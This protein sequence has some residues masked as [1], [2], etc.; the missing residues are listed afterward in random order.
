MTDANGHGDFTFHLPNSVAAGAFI[1]A[2]ATDAAGNTS[3]FSACVEA[4]FAIVSAVSRKTHGGA[5]EFDIPLPLSGAPGVECRSSGG[6]H[7]IV[8]AFNGNVVSGNASIAAGAG[9]VT[10]SPSFAGNTMTVN[11]SG[12]TEVQQITV[13]L[14]GVTD[15]NAHVVPDISVSMI[16]LAGDTNRNR[17][18]NASDVG[19]TKAQSGMGVTSTN[20]Y[21]DVNVNGSINA[22]DVGLV[23]SRSGQSVP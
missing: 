20:F 3:E 19:Q 23:K 13:S 21:Q 11:L 1:T 18:V 10:G 4:P 12:V 7:S 15:G 22:S 6:T 2:T 14:S 5:G 8:V 16:V 17:S 9:S